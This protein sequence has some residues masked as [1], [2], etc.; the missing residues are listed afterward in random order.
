MN[1]PISLFTLSYELKDLKAKT[2]SSISDYEITPVVTLGSNDDTYTYTCKYVVKF[3][4]AGIYTIT[5]TLGLL[6]TTY[7]SKEYSN[8]FL[9]EYKTEYE[10]DD[11]LILCDG[12]LFDNTGKMFSISSRLDELSDYSGTS[13]LIFR[14]SPCIEYNPN[15]N[16]QDETILSSY[17]VIVP[18]TYALQ[19][20][21]T[22]AVYNKVSNLSTPYEI[23][24]S[25]TTSTTTPATPTNSVCSIFIES[26][27]RQPCIANVFTITTN[28]SGSPPEEITTI[29]TSINDILLPSTNSDIPSINI[30]CFVPTPEDIDSGGTDSGSAS[31]GGGSSGNQT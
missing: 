25:D 29:T 16:I 22:N 4:Y 19:N 2:I 20:E 30:E 31:N 21:Y 17:C 1:A 24:S 15:A 27:D 8:S 18:K 10:S 9:S 3:R 14:F 11:E 23:K 12:K 5:G 7:V 28:T 26:S 6:K 13:C